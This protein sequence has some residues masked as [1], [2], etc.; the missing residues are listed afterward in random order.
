LATQLSEFR[1]SEAFKKDTEAQIA[2]PMTEINHSGTLFADRFIFTSENAIT[3]CSV[4]Q[5]IALSPAVREQLSVDACARTFTLNDVSAVDSVRCLLSGDAVALERSRNGLGRQF[6]SPGLE[7]ALAG[8]D[9]FDLDS[10]DVSI[11]SVEALDE[12]LGLSSFS[13]ASEDALL[14]QLLSLGDEYRS[15]LSRIES[16]FL[17][18]AG[19]ASLVEHFVFPPECVYCG[20]LESLILP[21]VPPPPSGW[22]SAIVPDFPELFEDFKTKHF[23]LLWRGSRDGFHCWDFHRLCDG[24]P[25]TLTVILDTDGNIFGGFTPLEW[26]SRTWKRVGSCDK[27]DTSL[28]SFIFTLKNPHNIPARRFALIPHQR[29]DAITVDT[30]RGPDF[31][32]IS[33]CD[34]C[35]V[36]TRSCTSPFGNTYTND[37]GLDRKTF[38]TGSE[39]FQVKEI[40]T[41]NITE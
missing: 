33:V 24:R 6:C 17:S 15:L 3:E 35:N 36:N 27:A 2:I 30:N 20:I 25:N 21:P 11:L 31:H 40:E 29:H 5:A 8:T 1:A 7:L 37:T 10:F 22:D 28:K 34:D 14:D 9:R 23:T 18:A 41:F 4:G 12:V 39:S 16:R 13:I 19:L 32:D 26:E 38:F